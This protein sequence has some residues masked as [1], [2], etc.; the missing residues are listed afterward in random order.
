MKRWRIESS[1]IRVMIHA[2]L[3][4]RKEP[5][6]GPDLEPDGRGTAQLTTCTGT[7]EEAS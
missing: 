5:T 6:C 7:E 3:T 2:A 4:G 1:Y